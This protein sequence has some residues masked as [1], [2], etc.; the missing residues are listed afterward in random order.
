[1]VA[2]RAA[3]PLLS[4]VI[5]TIGRATLSR[6]L[7][8]IL[9]QA[10]PDEV[11]CVV[12]ADVHGDRAP[13]AE[14]W[15]QVGELGML[16]GAVRMSALDAGYHDWGGAQ[17][18]A[19]LALARGRFLM[20]CDDDDI[21]TP[22]AFAA[23]AG[24]IDLLPVPGPLLFRFVTPGG[25]VLWDQPGVVAEG[26]IGTPCWCFPNIPALLGA[27]SCRY[28]ADYDFIRSTLDRWGGTDAARFIDT[29][30]AIARPAA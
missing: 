9:E 23:I 2:S 18:T 26:R 17:T 24:A 14:A 13:L 27:H 4:V 11:E 16:A 5:P 30:I 1:M 22:G 8:S 20:R 10:P 28:E 3:P 6:T 12:V 7:R 21:W 25:Q 19:G 29:V 15:R